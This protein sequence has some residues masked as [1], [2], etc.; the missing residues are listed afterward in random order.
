M[1]SRPMRGVKQARFAPGAK[2]QNLNQ[3]GGESLLFC[4]GLPAPGALSHRGDTHA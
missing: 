1:L 2:T 4:P 3:I